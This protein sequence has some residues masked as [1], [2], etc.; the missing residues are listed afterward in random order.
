M[1]VFSSFTGFQLSGAY[2]NWLA[3]HTDATKKCYKK[4][5]ASFYL[6]NIM[7][8]DTGTKNHDFPETISYNA[9][10]VF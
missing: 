5:Q 3:S 9:V 1:N 2:N 4:C 8:L 6:C 10:K 7:W